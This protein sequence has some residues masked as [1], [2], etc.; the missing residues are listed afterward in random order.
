MEQMQTLSNSGVKE[1]VLPE[2]EAGLEI[3]RQTLLSLNIPAG[4]ILQYTDQVRHRLYA[5]LYQMNAGYPTLAQLQMAANQFELVWITL[6]DGSFFTGQSIMGLGIRSRTGVS[7][8]GIVRDKKVFPNPDIGFRFAE[9]DSVAVMGNIQQIGN[10]K[11]LV[12]T[13]QKKPETEEK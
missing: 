7:V 2:F 10:F 5:P 12:Q 9:G 3:T 4:E 13:L 11:K 1:V 6:P 8:V